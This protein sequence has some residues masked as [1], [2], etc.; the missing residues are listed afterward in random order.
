MLKEDHLGENFSNIYLKEHNLISENIGSIV[1]TYNS[2]E[3]MLTNSQNFIFDRTQSF[4]GIGEIWNKYYNE[5]CAN[6]NFEPIDFYS[7]VTFA[8]ESGGHYFLYHKDNAKILSFNTDP[9]C[10]YL[11]PF[12]NQPE[13]TIFSIKEVETFSDFVE[14]IS[15]EWSVY[16]YNKAL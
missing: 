13:S 4:I 8:E 10:T 15:K 5:L 16:L 7:Y 3:G 1:E 9:G 11:V 6:N 12:S 2:G 14:K